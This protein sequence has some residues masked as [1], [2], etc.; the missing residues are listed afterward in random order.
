MIVSFLDTID[1]EQQTAVWNG[2]TVQVCGCGVITHCLM[3]TSKSLASSWS[4]PLFLLYVTGK[5]V[6]WPLFFSS[7][8][9]ELH[10]CVVLICSALNWLTGWVFQDISSIT[11]LVMC[12]HVMSL[13]SGV[14]L[15][16]TPSWPQRPFWGI[17]LTAG[18]FSLLETSQPGLLFLTGL[19]FWIWC[20]GSRVTFSVTIT[21]L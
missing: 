1:G 12:F 20:E 10:I 19:L 18:F 17:R 2:I 6:S 3:C 16:N 13:Q 5:L 15:Y 14:N 7:L 9:V 4:S 11:D 8:L 21:T